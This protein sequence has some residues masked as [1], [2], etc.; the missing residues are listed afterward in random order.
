ML[1]FWF[2]SRAGPRAS[3]LAKVL[4]VLTC[5]MVPSLVWARPS[6]PG[7]VCDVFKDAAECQGGVPACTLCHESTEPARWNVLGTALKARTSG[8]ADFVAALRAALNA[9]ASLDADSDGLSNRDELLRGTAPG[10]ADS[11]VGPPKPIGDSKNPRYRV[12]GYDHGFALRRLMILYCGRSPSFEE[13]QSLLATPV[14]EAGLRERLHKQLSTCL[15]SAYWKGEGLARLADKRIRPLKAAGPDSNI[16]IASLR[17]VIGDYNYDYRLWSYALTDDRDMRALLTAQ[18]HLVPQPDG[19]VREVKGVLEK[20]DQNALAGGQL[21]PDERR[22]GMLTTQ[23][24]LAINTMFS[25]LPRTSAAQAYRSYLGADISSNEGLR[26]VEGEPLDIDNKGVSQPR[27]ANCHSTLDPLSYAF[28]EYEGIQNSIDLQFGAYRPARISEGLPGWD[29]TKQKSM[30]LNQPVAN[31]VEWGKVAA[32]SD[33]FK[34]NMA[35]MFF[36]HAL[37]REP[38]AADQA[39]FQAMWRALASDG[40]SANK[41]IHRLVDSQ[42]FGGP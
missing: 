17:L 11:M 19:S 6:A 38:I 30:L 16:Q 41:L 42:S 21:V 37:G 22:A 33:E 7:V 9:E 4:C 27:C 5:S 34:R 20:S 18:Y 15:S 2:G 10:V 31:L 24:F 35:E 29:A 14:D 1:A 39:D 26:P 12:D 8:Q 36:R 23:W 25:A 32:N 13:N 3:S 28:A 40:Y